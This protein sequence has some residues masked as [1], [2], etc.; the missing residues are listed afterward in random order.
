M[1]QLPH[2]GASSPS[3]D[4]GQSVRLA[5]HLL[6]ALASLT[7]VAVVY[8]HAWTG[9]VPLSVA[10]VFAAIVLVSVLAFTLCIHT[11]YN[12]RFSDPSL[13]V[14]QMT[15]S[16]IAMAYL[17]YAA[18]EFRA[19]Q[20]PFYV[21][22]LAFGA[23]RLTT[24]QQLFVSAFFVA[25]YGAAIGLDGP[26]EA[27]NQAWW[28]RSDLAMVGQLALLLCLMSLI[29]GYVNRMRVELRAGNIELK[30]ALD[31]IGRI[32]TYDE[33]TGLYNRR[34][35]LE[36][37]A[38]E[39]KR[40]DRTGSAM[41]IALMDADHF[42]RFNDQYGHATGDE[43]L[44]MLGCT[45]LKS[46]RDTDYI[47]RYGGE[48][49]VVVLPDTTRERAAIPLERLREAVRSTTIEGMPADVRVTVSMGAAEYRRG[50]DV[51]ETVKR[52]D[53]AMYEAKRLGRDRIS[54]SG[55]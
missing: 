5:R 51:G 2:P 16:G 53:A 43:V 50:E 25:T 29:G 46:L 41:F 3:R 38:R 42:K 48:E 24:R 20:L 55:P 32:A 9:L 49:F 23:F 12:R 40:C 37:A 6:G 35:I 30:E 15:T 34:V 7:L 28:I 18:E 21:V 17:A 52:A 8:G 13:T 19:L 33:L 4:S 47:G 11:G 36:I 14:A 39:K 22:A 1:V 10:N 26:G 45:L 44:R 31:K 54:W 27:A